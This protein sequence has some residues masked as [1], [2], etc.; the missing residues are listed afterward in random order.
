VLHLGHN[1]KSEM[2]PTDLSLKWWVIL[3]GV[4]GVHSTWGFRSK[5]Q[6]E[7]QNVTHGFTPPGV[8]GLA[9]N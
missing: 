3:Y 7:M 9:H 6:F 5:S 8:F 4:F 2:S 1:L